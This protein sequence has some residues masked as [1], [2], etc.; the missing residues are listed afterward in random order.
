MSKHG[1]KYVFRDLLELG[2]ISKHWNGTDHVKT[3][4]S[5]YLKIFNLF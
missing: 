5:D 1:F 3:N 2:F 4:L